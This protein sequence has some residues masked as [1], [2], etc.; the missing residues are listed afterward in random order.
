MRD[1]ADSLARELGASDAD[2]AGVARGWV[3]DAAR[4]M[5]SA[6]ARAKHER[7]QAAWVAR[8]GRPA[9]VRA[10]VAAHKQP[11]GIVSNAA[12]SARPN[13]RG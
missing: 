12:R 6:D 1:A 5:R 2:G 4:V 13:G 8:V 7:A 11:L 3:R 9:A 10:W